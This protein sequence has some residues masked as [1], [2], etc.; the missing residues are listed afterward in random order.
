MK[1]PPLSIAG[2]LSTSTGK[3]FLMAASGAALFGFIIGHLAGNLQIFLGPEAINRYAFGL[4]TMGEGKL[5]WLARGGLI[6]AAAVHIWTS[7]R[8]T[9]ENKAARPEAY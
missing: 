7:V 4:R 6:L 5:L 9:L 3:K 1:A 8:L 2:Y